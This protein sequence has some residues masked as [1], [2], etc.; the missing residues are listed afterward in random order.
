MFY[1][2]SIFRIGN[3]Q[4][5][6]LPKALLDALSFQVND[7]VTIEVGSDNASIA[8]RKASPHVYDYISTKDLFAGYNGGYV[9]SEWDT[10]EPVGK[11]TF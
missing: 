5:I 2:S 3:S 9:P 4:G 8:I 11:E 10:E 7:S 6:R 1:T